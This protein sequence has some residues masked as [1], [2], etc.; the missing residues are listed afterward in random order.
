MRRRVNLQITLF[1][2]SM[3]LV[4]PKTG[5]P[6]A[7]HII[8]PVVS[9]VGR[10]AGVVVG[11]MEKLVDQDGKRVKKTVKLSAGAH[12]LRRGFCSRWAQ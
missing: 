1:T 12:D 5:Q 11:Q 6:Y 2:D 9:A 3:A 10:K 7:A 8:G 4:D